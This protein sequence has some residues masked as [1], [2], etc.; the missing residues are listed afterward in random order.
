MK[1]FIKTF[2]A[3]FKDGKITIGFTWL[4]F[5]CVSLTGKTP[6]TVFENFLISG[7]FSIIGCSIIIILILT[8]I[9]PSNQHGKN[10]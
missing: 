4:F 8:G 5:F 10:R 6:H 3:A 1:T 7:A 9:Y 2:W